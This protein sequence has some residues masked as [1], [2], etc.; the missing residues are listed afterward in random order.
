MKEDISF[1][2]LVFHFQLEVIR[3]S[4]PLSE[5]F[6]W[7]LKRSILVRRSGFNRSEEV[8]TPQRHLDARHSFFTIIHL[9]I[10]VVVEPHATRGHGKKPGGY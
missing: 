3:A 4:D 8:R 9:A 10:R 6:E 1:F 7:D 2:P 5:A